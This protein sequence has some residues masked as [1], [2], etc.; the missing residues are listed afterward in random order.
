MKLQPIFLKIYM[1]IHG[2][3]ENMK[4]NQSLP[5]SPGYSL[6]KR[7]NS[8]KHGRMDDPQANHDDKNKIAQ[9]GKRNENVSI[10]K[11]VLHR[12]PQGARK[13]GCRYISLFI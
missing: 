1:M 9:T 12:Y 11:D 8:Q 3:L 10:I 2:A 7:C 6:R 4:T 5:T 13:Q